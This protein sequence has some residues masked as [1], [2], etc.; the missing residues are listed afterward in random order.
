MD[1]E[2][3]KGKSTMRGGRAMDEDEGR[4]EVAGKGKKEGCPGREICFILVNLQ[5]HKR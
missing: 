5:D 2:W 1:R 3:L 4:G